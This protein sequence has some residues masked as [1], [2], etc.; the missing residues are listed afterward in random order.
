MITAGTKSRC[1]C[2]SDITYESDCLESAVKKKA[3]W[4]MN[5][6]RGFF[7]V[8][9]GGVKNKPMLNRLLNTKKGLGFI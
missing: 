8:I 1:L 9:R 4:S 3:R 5:S 2:Q 7:I 6:R